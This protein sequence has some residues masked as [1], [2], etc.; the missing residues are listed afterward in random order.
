[1]VS[2]QRRAAVSVPSNIAEGYTRRNRLE[3]RQFVN[4]AGASVAELE[5][6][7]ELSKR[8]GYIDVQICE[9]L[10]EKVTREGKMIT[11]YLKAI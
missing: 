7:I 6:H 11:N 4:I 10:I 2:Q 3:K 1:M 9:T 8:L 5:T